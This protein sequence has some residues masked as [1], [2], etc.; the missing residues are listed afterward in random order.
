VFDELTVNVGIDRSALLGG[1][2]F[3]LDGWRGEDRGKRERKQTDGKTQESGGFHDEV[4][5]SRQVETEVG[6]R[7]Q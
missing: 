7:R 5:E 3:D 6:E 1:V 4:N 2:E